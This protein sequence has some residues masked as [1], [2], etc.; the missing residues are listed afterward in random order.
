MN[1][2]LGHKYKEMHKKI[3]A[4]QTWAHFALMHHWLPIYKH[5]LDRPN[6]ENS[7]YITI[8]WMKWTPRIWDTRLA[9]PAIGHKLIFFLTQLGGKAFSCGLIGSN[10]ECSFE[11]N[12]WRLQVCN[13]TSS[14]YYNINIFICQWQ[15]VTLNTCSPMASWWQSLDSPSF[16]QIYVLI[17]KQHH[18]C[19]H[20][21]VKFIEKVS[22]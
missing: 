21:P 22:S 9:P 15:N 12:V 8:W 19:H 4:S 11:P 16:Y 18:S 7:L 17:N 20:K 6:Y 3:I 14:T 2:A 5:G 13:T 1:T 10:H